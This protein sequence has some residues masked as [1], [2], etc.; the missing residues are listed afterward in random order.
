MHE[1]YRA[2]VDA[3]LSLQID[4]PDLPDG[5]NCLPEITC[6]NTATTP[7]SGSRR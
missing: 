7:P 5:W 1:E 3:G 6:P 2:I 4:D